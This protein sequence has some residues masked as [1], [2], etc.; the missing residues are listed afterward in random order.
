MKRIHIIGSGPR[1]GTTLLAEVMHTCFNI[2]NHCEHEASIFTNEP[3]SGNIFLTKQ[4]GE[5]LAVKWPLRLNPNLYIICIIR[6]PRDTV[7]SS[8][9]RQPDVYWTGLRYWK[10]FVKLHPRL[11]MHPRFISFHYEDF[12]SYPDKIQAKI[13]D[14]IPSLEKTHKFSE[15][16]LYARPSSKSLNALKSIRPISPSGVGV[17]IRHLAR[18]K[19]QI[20]IHGSISDELIQHGYENDYNWEKCLVDVDFTRFKQNRPQFIRLRD[21]L[22]HQSHQL[23]E[24][25]NILLR[26][27]KSS[28]RQ[29][30]HLSCLRKALHIKFNN[31]P[32]DF[33][34]L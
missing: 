31:P 25:L 30:K 3:K 20:T 28:L 15:Y 34:I 21:R 29:S 32:T 24:V 10:Q 9:G 12:V 16:H 18:I 1:T 11:S 17:W 7:V 13:M 14:A 6:D 4:P 2:D 27:L 26:T 19:E 8:H 22:E 5:I 33:S 23:L